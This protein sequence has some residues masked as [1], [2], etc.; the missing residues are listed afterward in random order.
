MAEPKASNCKL[1]LNRFL[2]A[3]VLIALVAIG[4]IFIIFDLVGIANEVVILIFGQLI[5]LFLGPFMPFAFG[6]VVCLK[7]NLLDPADPNLESQGSDLSESKQLWREAL[8]PTNDNEM[9]TS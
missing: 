9:D 8:S 7:L 3:L 5:P 6:D 2:R 4:F 1:A